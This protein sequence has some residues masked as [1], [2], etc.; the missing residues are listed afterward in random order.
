MPLEHTSPAPTLRA[1]L[2]EVARDATELMELLRRG[3]NI[4]LPDDFPRDQLVDICV[5][6]I[7]LPF[8]TAEG[9]RAPL[10]YARDR[11]PF[12]RRAHI[13][14][15]SS[16]ASQEIALT[17]GTPLD[18]KLAT[19][20]SS[21]STA[22]DEYRR[23]A[24][25]EVGPDFEPEA[26]VTAPRGTADDVV[27]QASQLDERLEDAQ[28]TISEIAQPGSGRADDLK[29]QFQDA[30]GLTKLTSAEVRMPKVMPGWLRKTVTAL[31]RSPDI[32]R[33]TMAGMRTGIDIADV[34]SDRWH[35]FQHEGVK[36]VLDQLRKTTKA[37][38]RMADLLDGK[39]AATPASEDV[40][41]PMRALARK[42]ELQGHVAGALVGLGTI[43]A[44]PQGR[45]K[46]RLRESSEKGLLDLLKELAQI[47]RYLSAHRQFA[48]PDAEISS[49]VVDPTLGRA[50]GGQTQQVFEVLA[51][52]VLRE[53]GRP[54][55][56]GEIVEAFAARGFPI[57]GTNPTRTAW[58]RLWQAKVRGVLE[59]HEGHG[60]CL[61][62]VPL[63]LALELDRPARRRRRNNSARSTGQPHGGKHLLSETQIAKAR[64]WLASGKSLEE[65]RA[66]LGGISHPGL[67]NYLPGGF[68]ALRQQYPHLKSPKPDKRAPRKRKSNPK[69]RGRRSTL[70]P[71]QVR[72]AKEMH[73]EGKDVM[74][75]ATE[76]KVSKWIVYRTLGGVRE[77]KE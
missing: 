9:C 12:I 61:K 34:W 30:R 50:G 39:G 68:K 73:C 44:M 53:V 54:M 38:E 11:L 51:K 17:R 3:L 20:I 47:D 48:I 18:Q 15:E 62:G 76:L 49:T 16:P 40:T 70:S 36:F 67:L 23:L 31:K 58:N 71:E 56:S 59:H 10:E 5:T 26:G 42:K 21:V 63:T 24:A 28:N 8:G 25:D 72:A 45:D 19:L 74:E 69:P 6:L 77:A 32:I 41:A 52:M 65:V 43:D 55:Q 2:I 13:A 29:R 1:E 7:A 75:I 37:G 46:E 22:L 66:E 60:Y 64:E 27:A 57:G 14:T 35:E 33:K 4:P